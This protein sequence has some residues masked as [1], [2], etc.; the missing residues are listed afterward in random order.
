MELLV[1]GI[2]LVDV[3]AAGPLEG[4]RMVAVVTPLLLYINLLP[5]AKLWPHYGPGVG[6]TSNRNEYQEYF[7]GG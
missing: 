6:P 4:L 2:V 7:L 5:V 1:T 3:V